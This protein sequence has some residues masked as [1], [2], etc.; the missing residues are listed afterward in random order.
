V[1]IIR[2]SYF[3]SLHHLVGITTAKMGIL[4]MDVST[5]F[6]I[7]N[8]YYSLI[9]YFILFLWGFSSYSL[10]V[11]LLSFSFTFLNGLISVGCHV[12]I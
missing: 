10:G 5:M 8:N 3:K 6:I 11:G 1:T 12:G 2:G 9:E 7:S 4:S